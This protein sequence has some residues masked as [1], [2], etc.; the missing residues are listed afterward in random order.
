[1]CI[2]DRYNSALVNPAPVPVPR[3]PKGIPCVLP[4]NSR[5]PKGMLCVL[6]YKILIRTGMLCVLPYKFCR[7]NGML[8]VLPYKVCRVNGISCI[9]PYNSALVNPAAVAVPRRPKGILPPQRKFPL[10][11]VARPV[12]ASGRCRRTPRLCVKQPPR[13]PKSYQSATPVRQSA[14]PEVL[15]GVPYRFPTASLPLP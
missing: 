13:S 3:R 9:L 10:I 7:V 2:R 6:P 15:L 11:L 14:P 8:C 1:M 4:H 5:R 12:P